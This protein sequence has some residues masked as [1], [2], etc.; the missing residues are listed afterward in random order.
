MCMVCKKMINFGIRVSFDK[1]E[2]IEE[3]FSSINVPIELALPYYWKIYEPIRAHLR[4]IAQQIKHFQIEV[5]GIHAVQAPITDNECRI[6]GKETADFA[7]ILGAKVITL[8]P[9]NTDKTQDGQEQAIKNLEFLS[10][11]HQND[12]I[13]SIETFLGKRRIFTP[14]EI[15][16][17]NLPMTLDIAHIHDNQKIWDL[18]KMYR[19]NIVNIHLSAKNNKEHHLPIDNFCKDVVDY[20][21]ES[22][23]S[24][25]VILEYLPEFHSQMLVD[26]E[27]LKH[28]YSK[29][30]RKMEIC[31]N[32]KVS[33]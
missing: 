21:I 7:K 10:Q 15:V 30:S 32:G 12:I 16:S 11:L 23:W 25:N 17:F 5:L 18:L 27:F 14:D 1:I 2:Q 13:F 8:H 6:W 33:I 19:E 20:L 9:N 3:R 26:F 31:K 4:Q 22:K 24:G 28:R 29:T